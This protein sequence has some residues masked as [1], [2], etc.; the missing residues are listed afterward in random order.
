[1]GNGKRSTTHPG[2]RG[3]RSRFSPPPTPSVAEDTSSVFGFPSLVFRSP[4]PV[5]RFPFP[6]SRF[7]YSI[8]SLPRMGGGLGDCGVQYPVM[9]VLH[10]LFTLIALPLAVVVTGVFA[11]AAVVTGTIAPSSTLVL[12]L[13]RLWARVVLLLL[14]LPLHVE[15]AENIDTDHRYV[16]MANHESTIDIPALLAALPPRLGTRFLAK[17]SLFTVPFLGWAMRAMGFVP[18]DRANRSTAV[19]MFRQAVGKAEHGQSLLLFP[20]ET[21]TRDGGLLPFQ[22]GGFLLALRSRLPIVPVGIEGARLAMAAKSWVI[23]PGTPVTVRFGE[24][25]VTKEWPA[26]GRRELTAVVRRAVDELRGPRGHIPDEPGNPDQP[27]P[28]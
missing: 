24:P 10:V 11:S 12:A 17:K 14:A 25:V 27:R 2:A 26:T 5:F 8:S 3:A 21:R 22:R 15:G 9:R 23:R 13:S 28:S 7:P 19:G 6:V 18:V 20:E 1:M 16:F 4:F